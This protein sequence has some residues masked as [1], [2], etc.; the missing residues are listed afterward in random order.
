MGHTRYIV[1][2]AI[3]D[4]HSLSLIAGMMPTSPWVQDS[5]YLLRQATK[6]SPTNTYKVVDMS[7]A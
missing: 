6:R 5:R 3:K 4:N 2:A 7:L 1:L